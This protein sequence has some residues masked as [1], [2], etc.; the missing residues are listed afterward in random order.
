MC[1]YIMYVYILSN[2]ICEKK[3]NAYYR[4]QTNSKQLLY[5]SKKV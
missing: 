4:Q 2:T 5:T 3:I 1:I